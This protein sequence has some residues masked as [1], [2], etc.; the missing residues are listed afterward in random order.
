VILTLRHGPVPPGKGIFEVAADETVDLAEEHGFALALDAREQP[1]LS[2]NA[3]VSW[4]SLVF[5]R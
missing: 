5:S 3:Q 4:T 1:S 2:G